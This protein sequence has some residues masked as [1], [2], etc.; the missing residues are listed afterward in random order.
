MKNIIKLSI[1]TACILSS[2]S[3]QASEDLSSAF[4]EGKFSG[5]IREY[6]I[7]RDVLFTDS[8]NDFTRKANAIGGHLKFETA[9]YHN[10]KLGTAIYSTN[11]F[12]L[13]SQK[14]NA[15]VVDPT[16]LGKYNASYSFIGEGYLEYKYND[17][18]FKAGRQKLNTPFVDADDAKMVP[19]LFEAYTLTNKSIKDTTLGLSHITKIA[20]GTFGRVYG[21]GILAATSGYTAVSPS[22]DIGNVGHFKNIGE[23]SVDKQTNG[24]TVVSAIYENQNNIKF[25]LW[26]YYAH[27][28]VNTIYAQA[29]FSWDC[30]L[31]SDVKPYLKTQLIKQND[32]GDKLLSTLG[33]DGS[34]NRLYYG[35]QLGAKIQNLTTSI[36]YSQTSKNLST[37]DVYNHGIISLWGGMPAFTQSLVTRHMFLAG[38][39]AL[40]LEALYDFK[41][42]GLNLK[43][44]IYHASYDMATNNGYT[45]ADAKESGFNLVYDLESIKNLKLKCSGIYA[46]D[47]HVDNTTKNTIGWDEYRFSINYNF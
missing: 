7:Y 39:K 13:D 6:S 20:Q 10:L 21:G 14:T 42:H 17:T 40:K 45:F 26:D 5:Q 2:L 12:H 19:N 31:S 22:R 4:S 34:I 3:L 23:Y 32:I 28:I 18:I 27:D 35:T 41:S 1:T 8:S 43:A 9:S 29:D 24:I 15:T 38:T 25:Q 47:F 36:S 46:S 37:D 33:G 44:D 11:G 16:L 30:S